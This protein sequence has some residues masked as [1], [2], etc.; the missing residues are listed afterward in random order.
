MM[1]LN[2]FM[3]DLASEKPAPGGGS[4]SAVV[5]LISVSL[6]SMVSRLTQGKKGYEAYQEELNSIISSLVALKADLEK[7]SDQDVEAFN[8]I[9]SARK[10][11]KSTEQEKK[12]R[13]ASMER[14]MREAVRSPWKIASLLRQVM[15]YNDRLLTI[16][17]ANACTDAGAGILLC[18]AAIESALL[19]VKINLSYMKDLSYVEDQKLKLEIFTAEIHDYAKKSRMKLDKII[20]GSD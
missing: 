7:A 11:P 20:G 8:G 17:N 9:I 18:E 10:M 6:G 16:G 19:N 13:T 14:A 2:K 1:D 4:A 15:V 5:G 3:D 12:L